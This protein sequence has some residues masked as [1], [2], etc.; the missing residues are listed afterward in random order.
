MALSRFR[1]A[2]PGD[3]GFQFAT[4]TCMPVANTQAIVGRV[5]ATNAVTF[6]AWQTAS[7]HQDANSKNVDPIF[8]SA[9][10]LHLQFSGTLLRNGTSDSQG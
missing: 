1:P 3:R 8:V 2:L 5:G 6:T 9:T 10:D 7:R 4:T